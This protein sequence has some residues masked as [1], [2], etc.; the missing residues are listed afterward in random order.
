MR[1][2][3][4]KRAKVQL[5]FKELS[6]SPYS[7]RE[8]R[9]FLLQTCDL[10]SIDLE[11]DIEGIE[12]VCHFSAHLL[13][14][15]CVCGRKWHRREGCKNTGRCP[16]GSRFTELSDTQKCLNETF[17][18]KKN[19]ETPCFSSMFIPILWFQSFLAFRVFCTYWAI[20]GLYVSLN[21]KER[22]SG[23]LG[24]PSPRLSTHE[25]S[26]PLVL[27]WGL[28]S[29][30]T[31]IPVGLQSFGAQVL[32]PLSPLCWTPLCQT[33]DGEKTQVRCN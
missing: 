12:Q 26:L 4:K 11:I 20:E 27:M 18:E 17:M 29:W 10:S 25:A 23:L 3:T 16:V 5:F 21:R 13:L 30:K 22:P 2:K 15:S 9:Y 6:P 8:R 1:I 33:L 32:F 7:C 24:T 14:I 19:K 31:M 28:C